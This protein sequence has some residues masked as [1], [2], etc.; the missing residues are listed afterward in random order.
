MPGLPLNRKAKERLRLRELAA[1]QKE[2]PKRIV[3]T[4]IRWI[5]AKGLPIVVFRLARRVAILFE[6]KA[7]QV[8][9]FGAGNLCRFRRGR[10]RL[11]HARVLVGR[12]WTVIDQ[13]LA[14]AANDLQ[15]QALNGGVRQAHVGGKRGLWRDVGSLL[16]DAVRAMT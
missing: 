10:G 3:V 13:H 5:A 4:D 8:E 15:P 7:S 2:Q 1:P 6:M 11:G 9:G 12:L 16:P 14:V